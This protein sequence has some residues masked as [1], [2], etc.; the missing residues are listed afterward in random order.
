MLHVT[1]FPSHFPDFF[2]RNCRVTTGGPTSQ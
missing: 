1:R 2:S